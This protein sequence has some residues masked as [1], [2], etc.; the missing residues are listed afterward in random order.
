MGKI[1]GVLVPWWLVRQISAHHQDTKTPRISN[2]K[3]IQ[4]WL[5]PAGSP[6]RG[7]CLPIPIDS[8]LPRPAS[9]CRFQEIGEIRPQQPFPG[10]VE[11]RD[12]AIVGEAIVV[13]ST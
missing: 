1:L 6:S 10:Y 3:A 12:F 8:A 13:V 2:Y 7:Y 9:L 4:L 5:C 11:E